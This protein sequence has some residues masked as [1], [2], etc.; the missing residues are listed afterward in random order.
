M[1]VYDLPTLIARRLLAI[2]KNGLKLIVPDDASTPAGKISHGRFADDFIDSAINRIT[3]NHRL[4]LRRWTADTIT[5]GAN[6][7]TYDDLETC[8]LN[9]IIYQNR[10]G[11]PLTFASVPG[12]VATSIWFPLTGCRV[13]VT[14]AEADAL[15]AANGLTKCRYIITDRA[16]AGIIISSA[17]VNKFELHA[18]ALYYNADFQGVGDYSGVVGFFAQIGQWHAAI[19]VPAVGSVCIYDG[20]HYLSLT[21]LTGTAPSGDAVNWQVIAKSATT[22]YILESDTIKYD[23]SADSIIER[24]DERKNVVVGATPISLFQWGN[25]SV[26]NNKA[27]N[28]NLNCLNQRGTIQNNVL[29]ISTLTATTQNGTITNNNLHSSTLT[30]TNNAGTISAN[31]LNATSTLTATNNQAGRSI[32]R[33]VL[34]AASTIT[35]TTNNGTIE[36]NSLN[37]GSITATT[38]SGTIVSN[39][40]L[41]STIT[42]TSNAGTISG[43]VLNN[44][45]SLSAIDY[46]FTARN[47]LINTLSVVT[48]D[49]TTDDFEHNSVSGNVVV[50]ATNGALIDSCV[51]VSGALHVL[52]GTAQSEK[53]Y[54][55]GY[56]NFDGTVIITGVA[57]IPYTAALEY[58]G[59]MTLSST[60]TAETVT[61]M[62]NPPTN[63]RFRFH[64]ESGLTVTFT[65]TAVAGAVA[66]Q[67]VSSVAS[68][69]INGTNDDYIEFENIGG[70]LYE[71]AVRIAI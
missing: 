8:E 25:D 12:V 65:M 26:N 56:S 52:D 60:N 37:T 66:G 47:N 59:D 3:D 5:Y 29:N 64:P 7:K 36:E 42:A 67:F 46:T 38:N 27:Y 20:L 41:N 31:Q 6:T 10:S 43:N 71:T 40:V 62:T 55:S 9:D 14:K 32:S 69:V 57:T 33:N 34:S 23:Y 48:L 44:G 21:G 4:N 58:V 11:G 45:S 24:Q 16:D 51:I 19:V 35:A 49:V 28:S 17:A 61:A 18:E 53:L 63:Q 1:A 54:E 30:A 13:S 70:I 2:Y 50:Q 22:G 68:R 15:I 39:Q